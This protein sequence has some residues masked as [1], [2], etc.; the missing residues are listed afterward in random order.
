MSPALK[1]T[2][3]KPPAAAFSSSDSQ[4]SPIT[5]KH[6]VANWPLL[7]PKKSCKIKYQA[8]DV[9]IVFRPS[10][11]LQVKKRGMKAILANE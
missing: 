10:C 3:E 4:Y 7:I 11:K 1:N 9:I 5:I 2:V 8:S 6:R